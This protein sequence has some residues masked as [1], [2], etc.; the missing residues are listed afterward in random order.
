MGRPV[1]KDS[2]FLDLWDYD[3]PSY[4]FQVF[5]GAYGT[6]KS[7][8][9]LK[10]AV[11]RK[12][13]FIYMRRTKDAFDSCCSSPKGDAGNPFEPINRDTGWNIGLHKLSD[14]I[15]GIYHR[16]IDDKGFPQ[17]E[18]LPIGKALYLPGLAKVRGA[19]LESCEL[20]F[21]D[22]FIKELHEPKMRGEFRAIMR[23]YETIN[24]NKEMRG[25]PP[26]RLWMVSNAEDIYNEVLIGLGVVSD[27]ERMA[28][29]G[30]EHKYYKD[31]GLAIH[32]LHSSPEFMK[33]KSE[34]AIMKLMA[35]TQYAEVGLENKF[36]NNDFSLV[37]YRRL[38]G[39]RPLVKLDMACVYQKK[40]E[41]AIYVSY[42]PSKCE[43]YT[44][45]QMQD[46]LMFRRRYAI[47]LQEAFRE[48]RMYFESYEL[49]EFILE[50][51][52]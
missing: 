20:I 3:D 22:E 34:T 30:Q 15:A 10:G 47:V 42:A 45:S 41:R 52:F 13:D 37:E 35:G 12:V 44:A 26:C 39:Y 5:I 1:K 23:G 2:I 19:G 51:I 14:K 28:R 18:G 16:K 40:G 50:H 8:S 38:G 32:L 25:E 6:G 7:Y 21:Y 46:E 36:A 27:C 48:G 29:K 33:R 4:P 24:R 31:R 9:V 11:E 43:S 49:K 17:P